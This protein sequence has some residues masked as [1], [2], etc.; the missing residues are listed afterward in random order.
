MGGTGLIVM[1][2]AI[3]MTLSSTASSLAPSSGLQQFGFGL[4]FAISLDATIVRALL[5]PSLI[6]VFGRWSSRS[7]AVSA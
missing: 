4:A 6:A 5:V 2:A 7:H 1:A 3:V